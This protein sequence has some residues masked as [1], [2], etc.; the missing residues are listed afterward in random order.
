MIREPF[1]GW[2]ACTPRWVA[3]GVGRQFVGQVDRRMYQPADNVA[4]RRDEAAGNA[5]IFR[6]PLRW[7]RERGHRD[8]PNR[9]CARLPRIQFPR[10]GSSPS[11][12]PGH[13]SRVSQIPGGRDAIVW[14][15]AQM[16]A[17]GMQA[18]K[19]A[20]GKNQGVDDGKA[21]PQQWANLTQ[22][23]PER[24][25]TS[26]TSPDTGPLPTRQRGQRGGRER[27]SGI[28]EGDR[29]QRAGPPLC[30]PSGRRRRLGM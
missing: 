6:V 20:A 13:R 9:P 24:G 10:L 17:A 16:E 19:P 4:A 15:L 21:G 23:M 26:R 12:R 29:D 14:V 5:G 11:A 2:T 3:I 7:S 25:T 30:R 8:S 27:G 1:A 18:G 22:W 28:N